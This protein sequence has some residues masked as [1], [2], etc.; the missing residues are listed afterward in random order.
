MAFGGRLF[1]ASLLA[2]GLSTGVARAQTD[3]EKAAARA[4]A[5][6]GVRA[7]EDG[8]FQEA[9]DRL[10]RAEA[11]IH[12]PTHLLYLARAQVGLGKLISA[13]ETYIKISREELAADAP[14]AFVEAKEKAAGELAALVPKIPNVKIDVVGAP[15][16]DTAVTIDGAPMQ[17]ALIGL[18]RPIDP[19]SHT[20][21][22]KAPG[23]ASE[24]L[25]V[26][27]AEGAKETVTLTLKPVAAAPPDPA[28]PAA[29][30]V[31]PP[32]ETRS[33]GPPVITWVALGVGAV[34]V[35][36]GTVFVAQNHSKRNEADALCPSACP[37][38]KRSE[39]QKLDDDAD[40]AATLA[41]IGYGV[42][43]VGLGAGAVLLLT[44]GSKSAPPSAA[45]LRPL[46][47]R[48]VIGLGHAGVAGEF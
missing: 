13:Q 7:L 26:T 11:V 8:R 21:I 46:R 29:S 39:I 47:V 38:T 28:T 5:M 3:D 17:S 22:A 2:L 23:M 15:A 27:I 37:A 18:A 25:T 36:A 19:G 30:R 1:L 41:W 42:G 43:V 32:D 44:S 9:V 40:S 16:A 20:I 35:V 48:P 10:T 33:S 45:S 24:P 34:G 12:A 31:G 6:E 4:A 14:R